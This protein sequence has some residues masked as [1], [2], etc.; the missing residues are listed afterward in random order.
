[1]TPRN[2]ATK[3]RLFDATVELVG[4]RGYENTSVDD[5][6]E[7]AGL[8]KGT[9]YY[10]F[11]S[12]AELVDAVIKDRTCQ[13]LEAFKKIE[14]NCS[15]EPPEAIER[16]VGTLLEFLT[17]ESAYSRLLMSEVWRDDR[18]WYETLVHTRHEAVDTICRVVRSGVERGEFR[19]DVDADFAGYA[20]Y[21]MTAFCAVDKM[22]HDSGRPY[23]DLHRQ[24]VQTAWAMLRAC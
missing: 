14:V 16:L 22:T 11:A 12:K 17:K 7:L 9:V 18:P 13:L 5:I 23:E 15:D 19:A 20:L 8:A 24:I 10:H 3:R 6:V 2:A 21:G 1:M 4:V